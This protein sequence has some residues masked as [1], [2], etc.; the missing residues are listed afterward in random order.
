MATV[1]YL[2]NGNYFNKVNENLY[3]EFNVSDN[4]TILFEDGKVFYDGVEYNLDQVYIKKDDG[5]FT[6]PTSYASRYLDGDSY[7]F[8][9]EEGNIEYQSFF[10]FKKG[11][12]NSNLSQLGYRN[13]ERFI[14]KDRSE[15]FNSKEH[16]IESQDTIIE[17]EDGRKEIRKGILNLAKLNDKQQELFNKLTSLIE[18]N[19]IGFLYDSGHEDFRVVNMEELSI[20][21]YQEQISG[22]L[23][24]N[25]EEMCGVEFNIPYK[26][27]SDCETDYC[28]K[29]KSNNQ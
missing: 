17:Y 3:Q 18:E 9:N 2:N 19:N 8:I 15:L 21:Y 26:W 11:I 16:C 20:D 25:Y 12:K 29:R 27:I 28:L 10:H 24:L 6:L 7:F 13:G 4:T 22:T 1:K 14:I 23:P 5:E